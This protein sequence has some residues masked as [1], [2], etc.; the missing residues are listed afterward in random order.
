MGNYYAF[1]FYEIL[2][3]DYYHDFHQHLNIKKQDLKAGHNICVV[4]FK[5]TFSF[6]HG[7]AFLVDLKKNDLQ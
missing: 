5:P 3:V 4:Y 1:D 6:L 7:D 2:Y